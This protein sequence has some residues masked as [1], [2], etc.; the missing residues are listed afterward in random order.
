MGQGRRS[1]CKSEIWEHLGSS[2]GLASDSW[3]SAQ[4]VISPFMGS[5]PASGSALTARS[6]EPASDSLSLPPLL[7]RSLSLSLSHTHT[8]THTHTQNKINF[9]KH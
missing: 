1:C 8:H 9:R 4:D 3:V 6:L 2:V 5:S 7:S